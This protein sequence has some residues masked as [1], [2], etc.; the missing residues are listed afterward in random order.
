MRLDIQF[1]IKENENY[2]RYIRENSTWYKILN[3][4]PLMLKKFLEE[5]KD[6]YH[7]RTTDKI[8]KALNTLEFIENIVS[9]IN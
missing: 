6:T 8:S 4:N 1:K 3:R 2:T 7:L 9:N 5:V